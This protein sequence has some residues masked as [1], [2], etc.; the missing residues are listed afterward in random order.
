MMSPEQQRS[1]VILRLSQ[2]VGTLSGAMDHRLAL[3]AHA[4]VGYALTGARDSTGVAA[5]KGGLG[6]QNEVV[7][8]AG[9]CVFD[10]DP[11]IARVILSAAKFDPAMRSAAVIRYSDKL[12]DVL[13]DMFIECCT[14][15]RCRQPAG[16]STMDWGVAS[17]CKDG[18]PEAVI[19]PGSSPDT[20]AIYLF[21]ETPGDVTGNIIM[22]SNRIIHIEL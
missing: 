1:E 9:D 13:E 19:D 10:A 16:I 5:V 2:A 20:S 7:R 21:G 11:L 15:D 6:V 18:V 4:N 3:G 8:A 12:P 22:L 17:C 14:V